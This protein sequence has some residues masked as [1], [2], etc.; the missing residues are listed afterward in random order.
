MK[1]LFTSFCIAAAA[2]LGMQAQVYILGNVGDQGWD[3]SV[4]TEM[5]LVEG[6]TYTIKAHFKAGSYFSFT[7]KLAE[8]SSGWDDIAPYR[9]AAPWNNYV[10]DSNNF[11]QLIVCNE[12]GVETS[13]AFLITGEG[14]YTLTVDSSIPSLK[15][16]PEGEIEEEVI[17]PDGV[18]VLGDVN[19]QT[20]ATNQGTKL[21]T[22][23]NKVYTGKIEIAAATG[24]FNFTKGLSKFD[25]NWTGI[26]PYRF[27]SPEPGGYD[28]SSELG[29]AVAL[30]A[31]SCEWSFFLPQGRYILTVDMEA[32]TLV[33]V[34]DG[35]PQYD[36]YYI[37]GDE[38]FGSWSV[39]APKEMETE[40]GITYTYNAAMSG[41]VYF[42]FTGAKGSWYAI[43]AKRFGPEGADEDVVI[44]QQTTTQPSTD[45]AYKV[46]G[47]SG[48]YVITF[49]PGNLWFK[50][51]QGGK[52][53]VPGDV[54]GDD[55]VDIADVNACINVILG[56]EEAAKYEGRAD[57]NKDG[58]IDI[59]DVNNIINIIL[60]ISETR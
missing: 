6:T 1:K 4:G 11:D 21:A 47:A 7:T 46:A 15:V 33:A 30:S 60:G 36:H 40:D 56:A 45:K 27:G 49:N 22:T 51:E 5:T 2:T 32:R 9:F 52:V 42:V 26:L 20:W 35:S 14:D 43:N 59:A 17:T 24:Y 12:P 37:I 41:D 16:H 8:T 53:Y 50:V 39:S 55:A 23:D 10:I 48:K 34:A 29:V 54:N 58:S 38:P 13:N 31:D 19:G 44:G 3:P 57:V 25:A 28:L 18:Y